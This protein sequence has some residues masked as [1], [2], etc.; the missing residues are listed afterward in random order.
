METIKE[1]VVVMK[2]NWYTPRVEESKKYL[3]KKN[4]FKKYLQTPRKLILHVKW[5]LVSSISGG[6][7]E[8]TIYLIASYH[9]DI[10]N[11]HAN[12]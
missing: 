5:Q 8:K 9:N 6:V 11:G 10:A 4:T 7:T 3:K 2:T 12:E 1:I